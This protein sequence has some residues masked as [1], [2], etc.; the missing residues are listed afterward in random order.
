MFFVLEEEDD[1]FDGDYNNVTSE[2][3]AKSKKNFLT[4]VMQWSKCYFPD[5]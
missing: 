3:E 4:S 1:F 2:K 5:K